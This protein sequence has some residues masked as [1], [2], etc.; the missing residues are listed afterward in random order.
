MYGSLGFLCVNGG[1]RVDRGGRAEVVAE[2][3]TCIRRDW[4]STSVS[5]V[6]GFRV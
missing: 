2:K 5:R 3:I 4:S 1:Y 6:P